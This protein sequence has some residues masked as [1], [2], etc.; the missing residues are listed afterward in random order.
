[1]DE[2]FLSSDSVKVD[3]HFIVISIS[4]KNKIT[5]PLETVN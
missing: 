4:N 1:M 5:D 3:T 2:I